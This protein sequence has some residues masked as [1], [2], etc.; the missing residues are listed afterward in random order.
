MIDCDKKLE[1]EA[2]LVQYYTNYIKHWRMPVQWDDLPEESKKYWRC[3]WLARK[4][5]S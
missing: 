5:I 4:E 3:W 2:L 1:D